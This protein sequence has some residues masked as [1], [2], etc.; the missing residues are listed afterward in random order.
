M[1]ISVLCASDDNY[2]LP[3]AV[4]LFSSVKH[5]K[6][7]ESIEFLAIDDGIT[8]ANKKKLGKVAA[9]FG[10]GSIKWLYPDTSRI[11]NL[12]TLGLPTSTFLRLC[13]EDIVGPE[14]ERLLYLDTDILV[15]GDLSELWGVDLGGK[16]AGF[17]IDFNAR[18]V[19]NEISLPE[20]YAQYGLEKDWPYFNAGIMA[21]DMPRWREKKIRERV[22]AYT[23]EH[24]K[25]NRYWD[26]DGL[27]IALGGDW[28]ELD[29][30]W[31][32]QVGTVDLYDSW[33]QSEFKT[34]FA[35][36][37][38]S[39]V[40]QPGILHYLGPRKPWNGGGLRSPGKMKYLEYV[41]ECPFLTESEKRAFLMRWRKKTLQMLVSDRIAKL[42]KKHG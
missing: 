2:A 21:A 10:N 19:G 1:S 8:E 7:G 28:Q 37:R 4:M 36:V 42:T 24:H 31:N 32:I 34:K 5:L 39:L 15:T 18:Y 25:I 3:F 20:T 11:K 14:Q 12:S 27:N 38:H 13:A 35:A 30:R 40:N 29:W 23:H 9:H 41:K 16:T 26:Q 22:L 17:V 33:P 6:S